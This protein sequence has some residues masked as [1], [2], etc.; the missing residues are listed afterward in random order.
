MFGRLAPCTAHCR[1]LMEGWVVGPRKIPN[2]LFKQACWGFWKLHIF[3]VCVANLLLLY[4]SYVWSFSGNR[5]AYAVSCNT[6]V[7]N[8][9]FCSR[10]RNWSAK[11]KIQVRPNNP[12][13]ICVGRNENKWSCTKTGLIWPC[14]SIAMQ[15]WGTEEGSE[16]DQLCW[17]KRCF[18]HIWNCSCSKLKRFA[19]AWST[20]IAW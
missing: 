19:K 11:Q 3:C 10:H 18:G 4:C 9:Q 2:L 13:C 14:C 6:C 7:P 1:H 17:R 15:L 12:E 5:Y 16:R 8:R 20:K